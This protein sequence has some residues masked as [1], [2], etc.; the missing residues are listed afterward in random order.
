[1]NHSPSKT[2]PRA[3]QDGFSVLRMLN[4]IAID[5]REIKITRGQAD[6]AQALYDK[7]PNCAPINSIMHSYCGF[8]DWPQEETVRAQICR[9]RQHLEATRLTIITEIA[10]GYRFALRAETSNCA[11][12]HGPS[13]DGKP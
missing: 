5:G 10:T 7:Y 4:R 13:E 12:G 2:N 1:M 9:L 6:L 11:T 8:R 3:E